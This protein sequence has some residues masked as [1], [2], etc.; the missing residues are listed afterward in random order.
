MADLDYAALLAD[1]T[2]ADSIRR[3]AAFAMIY[4][5]DEMAVQPLIEQFYAGVNEATGLAIIEIVSEIGG[6]EARTL[7][8]DIVFLT[9][10][11]PHA[12][13]REAARQG[14]IRNDF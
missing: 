14:M 1:I 7:L 3:D 12:S 11:Y 6:F 4:A 2:G 13:W 5:E 8:E 10:T 9:E